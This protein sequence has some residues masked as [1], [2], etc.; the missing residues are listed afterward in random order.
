[1]ILRG[2]FGRDG[3]AQVTF[4]G[5]KIL[6]GGSGVNTDAEIVSGTM[7]TVNNVAEPE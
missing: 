4:E 5:R 1:M 7:Y 6:D 3:D 2:K